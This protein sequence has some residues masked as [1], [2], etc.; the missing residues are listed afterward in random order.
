MNMVC[1]DFT[2]DKECEFINQESMTHCEGRLERVLF[3]KILLIVII[4]LIVLI[5]LAALPVLLL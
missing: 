1:K 2:D 4:A 3:F 5:P